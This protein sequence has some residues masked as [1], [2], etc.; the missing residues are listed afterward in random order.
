[1]SGMSSTVF[2]MCCEWSDDEKMT[3]V[4]GNS[5]NNNDKSIN[6]ASNSENKEEEEANF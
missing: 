4:L 6:V 2:S 5:E 1:M 3:K